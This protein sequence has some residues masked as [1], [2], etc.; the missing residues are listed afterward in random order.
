MHQYVHCQE[1]VEY[2][3]DLQ[4]VIALIALEALRQMEGYVVGIMEVAEEKY[5]VHHVA[6]G[7][8]PA[9][10]GRPDNDFVEA[11]AQ[12]VLLLILLLLLLIKVVACHVPIDNADILL[13]L[14]GLVEGLSEEVDGVAHLLD[15][16]AEYRP[17]LN[18]FLA[19]LLF[20]L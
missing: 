20:G 3:R 19:L 13:A 14:V 8:E 16:C 18:C 1:Y 4:L 7:D 6:P 5:E 11:F 2:K 17:V 9:A 10:A 12:E 15:V